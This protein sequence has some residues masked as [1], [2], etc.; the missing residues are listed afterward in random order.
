M[1]H[2]EIKSYIKEIAAMAAFENRDV[3]EDNLY[4][5][6]CTAEKFYMSSSEILNLP[7]GELKLQ[8]FLR[9]K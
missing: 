2:I 7:K 9:S 6:F 5:G 8:K 3:F 4:A 1:Y